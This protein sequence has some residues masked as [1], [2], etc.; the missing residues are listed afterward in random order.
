MD[1]LTHSIIGAS[2]ARLLPERYRRPEIY[3]ASVIANNLADSDVIVRL[4]PGG[5]P[6]DYLIHHRGYTH[7]FLAVPALGLLSAAIAKRATGTERWTPALFAVGI[8]GSFLHVAADF[9]NNYGVHPLTPFDD[10]WFFGDSV[11]IV[12][13][14]I[15]FV[16]VP[17]LAREADR[18]WSRAAW[19]LLG[20]AMLALVWL[21]P[22]FTG[23]LSWTLT[24]LFVASAAATAKFR[25]PV[26][27]RAIPIAL[28]AATL[29][30]FVAGGERARAE[31]R[32]EWSERRGGA[33]PLLDLASSPAPGNPA[34]W[35]VW[36]AARSGAEFRFYSVDVSLA[37]TL[38]PVDGCGTGSA[39]SHTA[40]YEKVDFPNS[41]A[42]RWNG[43][44]RLTEAE[45]DRYRAKSPRFRRLLSFARFPFIRE[46]P[47]GH[48]IAGDLRYDREKGIG[49][50]EVEI[51]AAGEP[52][53]VDE[54]RNSPWEPPFP[55]AR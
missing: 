14:L 55:G 43:R 25:G 54:R 6:F 36:I 12:E 34:C 31:V 40:P 35:N 2:V 7:T 37:S 9:L 15:W 33:E 27:G 30:A 3:W 28:F 23:G 41:P 21:F 24:A 1:N 10:R 19:I 32:T 47:D 49:F 4:I 13:P 52:A 17:Y 39:A 42:L 11:F 16:L 45:F 29:G 48:A 8:L 44:V 18:P 46:F 51:P 20:L 26:L 38:F 53:P 50:A 22:L 5:T